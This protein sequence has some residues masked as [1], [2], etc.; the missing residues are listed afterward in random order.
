MLAPRERDG[1]AT[2]Y[3][4]V[5]GPARRGDAHLVTQEART[6]CGQ[7]ATGWRTVTSA[8]WSELKELRCAA[9]HQEAVRL[10]RS[11]E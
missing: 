3:H 6:L 7:D 1:A 2:A 11:A 5:I 8:R 10:K 4:R 9:C